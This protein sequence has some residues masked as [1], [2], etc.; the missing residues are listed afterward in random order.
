MATEEDIPPEPHLMESMRAVGYT[1][2]AAIAD[3]ID[4]SITAG[5]TEIDLAFANEPAPHVALLDNGRGMTRDGAREA[6]RL[7]G[8]SAAETRASEDLGRFG[9]GLKTASLSQCRRLT[10]VSK[11]VGGEVVAFVWDLDHLADSGRWSLLSL[12]PEETD[13]L[14]LIDHLEALDSGTL[15]VW[16]NLDQFRSNVGSDPADTDRAMVAVRQ[17][18]GLVFHRFMQD[19]NPVTIRLNGRHIPAIDPFLTGHKRTQRM[20]EQSFTVHGSTVTVQPYT[21]PR[22]ANLTAREREQLEAPG[23]L[24]DSQGFYIYRA[25]RLVIW[26][27]WFR[28]QP[29]QD[30]AKLSRIQVD[31]PNTLDHLWAL[32][33]KKSSAQPPPEVRQRLRVFAEQVT[34]PSKRTFTFRGRKETDSPHHLWQLVTHEHSFSYSINRDHPVVAAVYDA[35][36]GAG[37]AELAR[38]LTLLENTVPADDIFNRLAKDQTLD[39][40]AI[41]EDILRNTAHDMWASLRHAFDGAAGREEFVRAMLQVEPFID[42]PKARTILMEAADG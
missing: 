23:V 41:G 37:E 22:P 7:A 26:G 38:L 36:R 17:H 5:A 10:I 31:V 29:R 24:R 13:G 2:E 1:L 32:D 4:N 11:T 25:R 33:I 39:R 8:R 15:V 16:Q 12:S 18:L 20:P 28:I 14:P 3:L 6:M 9:L 35:I 27:T 21:V 30:L 34:E 19:R 42:Q 40:S